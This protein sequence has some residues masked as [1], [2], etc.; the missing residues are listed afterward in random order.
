[1]DWANGS[2]S[3]IANR[4]VSG[5][6]VMPLPPPAPRRPLHTRRIECFGYQRDDGMWDI[7]GH[8]TDVK[9][10][11]FINEERGRVEPGEPVHDM[12]IR[13]TV[14]EGFVVR[15][16]EAVTER[17]PFSI[18]PGIAPNFKRLIGVH[19]GR[20]WRKS[21][22]DRLGGTEG[23]THL[24]ELLG[25]MATVA[26]QTMGP[27]RDPDLRER[28]GAPRGPLDRKPYFIDGCHAWA[29]DGPIVAREFP[30]FFVG[31]RETHRQETE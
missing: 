5:N 26:F 16:V 21:V 27:G 15:D 31:A 29:S 7:E 28:K 3:P 24:V 20:G 10:Y 25:P 8:I 11:A 13:L 9:T 1:M 17:A 2:R 18:C 4:F 14:D 22:R 23:C 30:E 19:I 12:W 6:A